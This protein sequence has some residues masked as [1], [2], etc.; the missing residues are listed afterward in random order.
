MCNLCRNLNS[1][2]IT[3]SEETACLGEAAGFASVLSLGSFG[4]HKT[5]ETPAAACSLASRL[6]KFPLQILAQVTCEYPCDLDPTM[7]F[8]PLKA[9]VTF[10][11]LSGSAS[12]L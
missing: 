12:T 3:D 10:T 9:S 5:S 7:E 1:E 8:L 4:L 11:Q 6:G 2:L